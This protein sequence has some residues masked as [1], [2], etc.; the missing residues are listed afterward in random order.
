MKTLTVFTPTYNRAH[1]L[2]RV[3]ESLCTQTC[4]DFEWLVIDDGSTDFTGQL[5]NG[6]IREN[7]IPVRY[8]HKE[9]GGLHT[10][11]NTAYANIDTELS[12]CVDSDD[13]MPEDAVEIIIAEW[14]GRNNGKY[15]GLIGLDFSADSMLPIGGYFPDNLK[16]CYFIDLYLKNIHRGD[17]KPV[18]RTDLMKQ[19][20]PQTGFP[21]E[22]NF[23]PVY[24]LLK[25][26]DSLPLLVINKNLCFVDYQ[27]GID[28][29]SE[30][31]F[32]QYVDS[33][34]SFAK[35]RILEMTLK[36]NTLRNKIRCAIHYVASCR[37][38][39]IPNC[40]S[41]SPLPFLTAAVY[42]VGILLASYIRRKASKC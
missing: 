4:D 32:R 15:L 8:I 1:T 13:F 6:F 12:V 9:N 10:A 36:R 21:C 22:K 35:L 34:R 28:S 29:M 19:V 33:P 42:P 11:Y 18:L 17:T 37:L 25:A 7:R 16:E 3:Y 20:S 2:R 26:G 41:S 31:I 23:N 5:V 24:S 30:G 14:R 38:G 40:V 27:T 39:K